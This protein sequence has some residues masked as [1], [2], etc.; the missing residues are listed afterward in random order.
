MLR[1]TSRHTAEWIVVRVLCGWSI[2]D[3]PADW[4][5]RSDDRRARTD[6]GGCHRDNHECSAI[7]VNRVLWN[8]SLPQVC[9]L[10]HV[11]DRTAATFRT[12]SPA[13]ARNVHRRQHHNL[14]HVHVWELSP[15]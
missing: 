13:G 9:E 6:G 11:S 15:D 2:L 10:K 4:I 14:A 12:V 7:Y 5:E 1:R 8:S 3:D